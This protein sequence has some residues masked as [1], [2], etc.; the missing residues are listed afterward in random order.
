MRDPEDLVRVVFTSAAIYEKTVT[1]LGNPC[2]RMNLNAAIAE[3]ATEAPRDCS[4][5][6]REYFIVCR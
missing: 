1:N 2:S 5:V 4:R 3:Y 6:R